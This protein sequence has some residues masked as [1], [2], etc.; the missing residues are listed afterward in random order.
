MARER[1]GAQPTRGERIRTR[2]RERPEIELSEEELAALAD[3][4][5]DPDEVRR[6]ARERHE[7]DEASLHDRDTARDDLEGMVFEDDSDY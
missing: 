7:Q 6:V 2:L 4:G 1:P 5:I 3:E